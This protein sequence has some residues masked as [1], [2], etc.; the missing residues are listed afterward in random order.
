MKGVEEGEGESESD[1]G[2][3]EDGERYDP[4]RPMGCGEGCA[5]RGVGG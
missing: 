5:G 2:Q 3:R 4:R 1:E